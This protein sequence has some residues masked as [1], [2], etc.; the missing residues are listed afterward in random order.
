MVEKKI[1]ERKK[2]P[3]LAC[4]VKKTKEDE[5][6]DDYA[7]RLEMLDQ[8]CHRNGTFWNREQT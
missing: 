5:V 4:K 6:K 2:R 7:Y 8:Q 1:F 3:I